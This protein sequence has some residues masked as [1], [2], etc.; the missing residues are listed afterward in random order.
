MSFGKFAKLTNYV[1]CR[2]ITTYLPFQILFGCLQSVAD[3]G[4]PEGRGAD[5]MGGAKV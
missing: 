4:F 5:P 3:P 2:I 1:V